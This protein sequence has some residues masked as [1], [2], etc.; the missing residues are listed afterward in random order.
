MFGKAWNI[1]PM[2]SAEWLGIVG[3]P[4]KL[5]TLTFEFP[6]IA[7]IVHNEIPL[8]SIHYVEFKRT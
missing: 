2:A 6:G 4:S 5:Q 1:I 8:N 3:I 7:I